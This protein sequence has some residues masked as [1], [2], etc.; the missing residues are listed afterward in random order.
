MK[1]ASI[2]IILA[3]LS[4][5]SVAAAQTASRPS[6]AAEK[7]K[8]D[9]GCEAKSDTDTLAIVNGVKITVRDVEGPAQE[10]IDKIQRQVV[11][12]RKRELELQINSK[13]LDAEAKKRGIST[14]KLLDA[15]VVSKVKEPTEA[16]A[17]AFYEQNEARIQGQFKDIKGDLIGYLRDQRQREQA[18]LLAERLRRA[19]KVKIIVD[20][21]TAPKSDA[22]RAR[23]FATINGEP[24]T[25]ADVENALKPI[26]FDAQEQVYNLRNRWLDLKINNTLLE[27]EAQKRKITTRALLEAEIVAGKK[28]VTEENARKFYEENKERLT[29]DFAKLKDQIIQHLGGLDQ[30]GRES[31]FADRLRKAAAVE[32]FLR[33][34]EPPVLS[35]ATDDQPSKGNQQ[36]AVTIVEF[37]D[38][39][40]PSCAK[41]H[42]VLE[43]I[44]KEYG[45]RVRIVVRDY[46]LAQHS[47]APKAAEAA[48][49]AREQGKYWEYVALLFQNHSALE[50]AKLKEYASQVGLD[51]KTFDEAL[52]SGKHAEQVQRDL[53]EGFRAG[54]DATPTLF[55]NGLRVRDAS[56]E[57]LKMAIEA[58]LKDS[59]KR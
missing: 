21:A 47:N 2:L 56:R 44:I 7:T 45:D 23:V 48:E 39:Q 34:P 58:A 29:G 57:S 53:R 3:L 59:A 13:L 22:D 11:E 4:F 12:A 15:E 20:T 32:I 35:I 49:A 52:D 31:A 19:A 5:A 38:F 41:T 27:H 26:I 30:R 42:P 51:R 16:E 14:I 50:V 33:A 36:A 24:I 25:S 9:C 43:E 6:K 54:V 18:G 1:T 55:V 10:Q 17:Q 46:P 37:T 28:P 8:E 40:C